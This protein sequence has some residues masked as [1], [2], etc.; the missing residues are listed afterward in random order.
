MSDSFEAK[1]SH[2]V[3]DIVRICKRNAGV[4]VVFLEIVHHDSRL[5]RLGLN[6]FLIGSK[7]HGFT[8]KLDL[9]S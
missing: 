5:R 3:D 4:D 7:V 8:R 1:M 2:L 6:S 9:P